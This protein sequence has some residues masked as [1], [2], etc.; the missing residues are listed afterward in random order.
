M[1]TNQSVK[2]WRGE[3]VSHELSVRNGVKQGG[4]LS[5]ILFDVHF[6]ELLVRSKESV[7]HF[8]CISSC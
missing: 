6:D 4:V 5:Q 7:S 2:V 3:T 8:R 1:F